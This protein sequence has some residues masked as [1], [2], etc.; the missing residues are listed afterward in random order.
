M[1]RDIAW[2]AS[3]AFAGGFAAIFTSIITGGT[4]LPLAVVLVFTAAAAATDARYEIIP[5]PIAAAATVVA[6]AVWVAAGLPIV[7][8]AVTVAAALV[9]F[10]LYVAGWIGAGDVKLLPAL[11]LS[12]WLTSGPTDLLTSFT[13]LQVF[14]LAT[15][16]AH[17][18]WAIAVRALR[19]T[20]SIRGGVPFAPAML[21]GGIVTVIA[22][23]ILT[24]G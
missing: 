14:L 16:V 18:A 7:A 22:A 23:G 8:L 5:N 11:I 10:G 20:E 3:V 17:L 13:L 4:A 21:F 15:S 2:C 6:G 1:R 19:G 12:T 24:A 9:L